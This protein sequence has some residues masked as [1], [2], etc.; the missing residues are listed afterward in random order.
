MPAAFWI[1]LSVGLLLLLA[2]LFA[3]RIFG[4]ATATATGKVTRA[5][6]AVAAVALM[7]A[8]AILNLGSPAPRAVTSA[9]APASHVEASSVNLIGAASDEL[10]A[11]KVSTAPAVPDGATA[12]R[13]QMTAAR[14]A[15]EAYDAATNA[16]VKCV[17]AAVE[18]TAARFRAEASAQ[19]LKSLDTFG[20]SAHNTAI[21]QEQAVADQFNREVRAYKAKHPAP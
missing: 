13:A 9:V 21:D 14:A 4:G 16:Y 15:F 17:D 11:C 2:A 18:R 10:A 1:G 12:S 8:V 3:G 5:A 6:I 20:S 19:D 7:A